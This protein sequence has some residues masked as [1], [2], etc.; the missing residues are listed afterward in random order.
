MARSKQAA[1]IRRQTSSEYTGK[2]DRISNRGEM[3]DKHT[4]GDVAAKISGRGDS[5]TKDA[6]G[7]AG[8]MQL[9]I[10]V[11]GIYGSL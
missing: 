3:A 7:S 2:H 9:L 10:C 5:L 11:A 6:S 1:P 8:A 4:N